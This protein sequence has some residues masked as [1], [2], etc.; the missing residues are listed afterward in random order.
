[1]AGLRKQKQY[2]WKDTNLALF[3]SSMD[4]DVKKEAASH[5]EAWHHVG[6]EVGLLIWRIEKFKVKEW[7]KK[8]YG[9]FYEGDSYI[10]LNTYLEENGERFNY[11]VHF[12]I[13]KYSTQDEYCAA[14]YKTVELDTFLDDVPIQHREVQGHESNLFK[15]YFKNITLLKGG[16]DSGFRVVTEKTYQSRLLHFCGTK[17]HVEIKEVAKNKDMLDSG[18]VFILDLGKTIY[19]WNGAQSNKD[20]KFKAAMY[21]N[22]LKNSQSTAITTE[23]LEEDSTEPDHE[24]YKALTEEKEEETAFTIE[25]G[26]KELYRLSD[27]SGKVQFHLEKKGDIGKRD[28]D[29]KDV[30]VIDTK[31]EIVVWIGADSSTTEKNN[32]MTYAHNYLMNKANSLLPVTRL[33]EGRHDRQLISA[34]AA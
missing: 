20:E 29:S 32:A 9:L 1:M 22:D 17:K 3:G 19:Q 34:L 10:V 4:R 12:W 24:F 11:D 27:S 13:G 23:V 5:E 2:D 28:L 30:F 8:D 14:A 15:S 33:L 7:P 6:K 26:P 21:I 31:K 16:V 18:D 25:E